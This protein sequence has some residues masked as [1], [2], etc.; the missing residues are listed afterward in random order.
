MVCIKLNAN[1]NLL[2]MMYAKFLSLKLLKTELPNKNQ[3]TPATM[4]VL[5]AHALHYNT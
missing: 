3:S 4:T 5:K 2:I 1:K